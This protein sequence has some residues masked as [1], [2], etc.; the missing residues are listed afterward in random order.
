ME[1]IFQRANQYLFFAVLL[2]VVLYFAKTLLIPITFAALLAML[3]APICRR[4][5]KKGLPRALS[6]LCCLLIIVISIATMVAV[7]GGQIAAFSK[8]FPKIEKKAKTF[9]S[10]S[11]AYI[12]EK[13]GVT[14]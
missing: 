10:Q 8:E 4:L 12:Q 2:V 13:L 6:T 14:P 5:D 1:K 11:Q 7:I 3:M 9:I